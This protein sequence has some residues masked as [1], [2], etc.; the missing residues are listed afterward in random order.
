MLEVMM[1]QNLNIL[2]WTLKK[3]ANQEKEKKD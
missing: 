3:N 2:F 1:L